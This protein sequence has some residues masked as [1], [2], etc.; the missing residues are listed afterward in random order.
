MIEQDTLQIKNRQK[1]TDG[2]L[3]IWL[4]VYKLQKSEPYCI[5]NNIPSITTS[6]HNIHTRKHIL[7]DHLQSQNTEH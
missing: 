5:R 3:T 1:D 4:F 7:T 6:S 2:V